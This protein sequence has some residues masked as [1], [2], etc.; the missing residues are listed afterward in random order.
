MSS[1]EVNSGYTMCCIQCW[2]FVIMFHSQALKM[3]IVVLKSEN[4]S[5]KLEPFSL[6]FLN[7][8]LFYAYIGIHFHAIIFLF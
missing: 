3:A 4:G 2:D 5:I 8:C 7:L 6:L 1:I